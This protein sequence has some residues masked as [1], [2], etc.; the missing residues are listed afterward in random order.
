MKQYI[1]FILIFFLLADLSYSFIQHYHIALDGDM[2]SIILPARSYQTAMEHPL[3][4]HAVLNNVKY[5]ATNRYFAH[6]AMMSYFKSMPLL[7]QNFTNPLDS[8]YLS[9]AIAKTG[10]QAGLIF[11]LAVF[12]TGT[13]NVFRSDFLIA[14]CLITPL[15]QTS[16]Y[17]GFMGVIDHAVT[18]TFFY[19]LAMLL[20]LL[21]FKPFFYSGF[22]HKISGLRVPQII[23]LLF[24]GVIVSF[25]SALNPAIIL[26]TCFLIVISQWLL[27]YKNS[28]ENNVK[29]KIIK[30]LYSIP[31]SWYIVFFFV[32]T[33]SLYS[34]YL[35]SYN[36]ENQ[37]HPIPLLQRYAKLPWGLYYQFTQ[38]LGMPLLIAIIVL[39]TII[40]H[41]WRDDAKAQKIKKLLLWIGVFTAIYISLL[42]LGGYRD[43]RPN[44]IRR[45][46]IIP[47]FLSLFFYFGISSLHIIQNIRISKKYFYI[48]GILVFSLVF[49]NA[50]RMNLKHNACEREAIEEIAQSNDTIVALESDCSVMSWGKISDFHNSEVNAQ[51]FQYWHITD[52]KKMYYHK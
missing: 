52:E 12:C 46:S 47:V 10:I 15:F 34:L 3:G 19:A 45:D 50:D 20:L 33:F 23:F 36:S 41:K 30:M 48:G 13:T 32:C 29:Y 5:P 9:C 24:L 28:N 1:R 7:L 2:A 18:Y 11:L 26:I 16:G 42:P 38:K 22:H 27:C 35:G 21:F 6:L 8:I 17:H 37:W 4:L 43:Y 25:N 49:M 14:A 39:N 44:I 51:M 31:L 40:L